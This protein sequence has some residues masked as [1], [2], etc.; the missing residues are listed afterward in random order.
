MKQPQSSARRD[1]LKRLGAAAV[2]GTLGGLQRPGHAAPSPRDSRP[3]IVLV[4]ADDMG[5]SDLGCYGS[6]IHTPVLDRLAKEGIQ[7]T[8]AYNTARCCPS[9]ASLLTGLYAHQT[10]I[11]H[12]TTEDEHDFDYG[13]PGYRGILNRD[14][15]TIA[16]ALRPAGYHTWMTGKWHV[17]TERGNWPLDRG[18]ERYY[19]IIRGGSNYF[20][21]APETRLAYGNT[22][23]PEVPDDFYT[24]D[25]FT[26]NAIRFIEEQTDQNP[27]F[28]Y[29][30]YNAP[31]W[32]LH[33]PKEDIEKYR[34]S[35]LKGWD[36]LREERFERQQASGLLDPRWKLTGRDKNV[37]SWDRLPKRRKA[38]LDYRMASYAAQVDRLDQNIGRLVN[39]LEKAGKLDNTLLIFMSDN[40]G[41]AEGG[42]FGGGPS[43]QLGT[44]E[45]YF[46]TYG[47]GWAN[48]SNTPFRRYKHWVHEGGIATPFIVHWPDTIRETT[49]GTRVRQPVHIMDLMPTCLELAGAAYPEEYAGHVLPPLEG[50]SILPLLR[51]GQE[52]IHEAL[53]WEHEGNCAVR[54]GDWKLVSAYSDTGRTWELY[55]LN[56]DRTETNDVSG[57]HSEKAAALV[58]DYEKWAATHQVEPWPVK[59]DDAQ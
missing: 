45:G 15:V 12:M 32:P 16:E 28:L 3:N 10:G 54:R 59:K 24:T 51:N 18:F 2:A 33:A 49:A 46:L 29:V 48:A 40:G 21:P 22:L 27:F 35:Y 14:C 26:D 9:R 6:E 5:F 42:N 57:K 7:F 25:A 23:I 34:G 37:P 4:L 53:Y 31:H 38:D 55:M 41:C 19:G 39:C 1:F 47:R 8:Q 11:G 13:R 36:V 52:P 17:G 50:K 30:A 56:E 43:K 20:K 58:G 44:K